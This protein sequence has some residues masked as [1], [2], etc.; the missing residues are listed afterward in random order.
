MPNVH[1]EAMLDFGTSSNFIN[2]KFKVH[3]IPIL[4]MDFPELLEAIDASL[5]CSGPIMHQTAPWKSLP[6]VVTERSCS[7]GPSLLHI[8][9]SSLVCQSS[10]LNQQVFTIYSLLFTAVPTR[11]PSHFQSMAGCILCC[12]PELQTKDSS[13]VSGNPDKYLAYTQVFHKTEPRHSATLLQL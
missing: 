13:K 5:L 6:L 8:H 2:Q 12:A 9:R 4:V 1:L 7:L 10:S 3:Q 11:M